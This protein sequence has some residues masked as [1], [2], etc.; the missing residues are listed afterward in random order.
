MVGRTWRGVLTPGCFEPCNFPSLIWN[1]HTSLRP[2]RL[3]VS[4]CVPVSSSCPHYQR[5][6]GCTLSG[7]DQ[8]L[9][10]HGCCRSRRRTTSSCSSLPWSSQVPDTLGHFCLT[11][12]LFRYFTDGQRGSKASDPNRTP[13]RCVRGAVSGSWRGPAALPGEQCS[14][15][16]RPAGNGPCSLMLTAFISGSS[17]V[18][19]QG[20]MKQEKCLLFRAARTLLV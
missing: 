10:K 12:M 13:S 14:R 11:G 20:A 5:L 15:G 9:V 3:L 7:S 2:S 17:S 18:S 8:T 1:P 19:C 6:L 4:S 16:R